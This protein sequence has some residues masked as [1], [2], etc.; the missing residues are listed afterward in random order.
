[1]FPPQEDESNYPERLKLLGKAKS[2]RITKIT[3]YYG[4]GVFGDVPTNDLPPEVV[5]P[6]AE[7]QTIADFGNSNVAAVVV[8][9]ILSSEVLRLLTNKAK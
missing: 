5:L 1:M 6:A 2:L 8:S 7:L 3:A 9:P 4:E